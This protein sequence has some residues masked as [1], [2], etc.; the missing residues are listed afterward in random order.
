[1]GVKE[2][3]LKKEN[4]VLKKL[5]NSTPNG[6]HYIIEFF[7][8]RKDQLD[9]VAFWKKLLLNSANDLKVKVLNKHFYK[10]IPHGITGYLLLSASHISIHTW[11]EYD[12]VACDVFS[13]SGDDEA[14]AIVSYIK[15]SLE[16]EK[17][18]IRKIKRGFKVTS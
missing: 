13:C 14:V 10:F 4:F 8:C 11:Y 12:Y 1:V 2:F 18:K 7:G 3:R 16:Y 15:K 9:A 17:I 5:K 6:I